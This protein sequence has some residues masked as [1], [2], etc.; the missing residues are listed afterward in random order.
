MKS[1]NRRI[2]EQVL[3]NI[4]LWI[5]ALTMIFPVL[6]VLTNSFIGPAEFLRYYGNIASHPTRYNPLHFIPDWI[7]LD[8]FKEVFLLRPHY[9]MKFWSSM[10]ISVTIVAG[11]MIIA[12]LGGYAFSRFRFPCRNI[13]FF[14]IILLMMLPLQVTLVPNYIMLDRFGLIGTYVAVILP[15]IFS[16]FGVF[17]MRQIM[18]SLPQSMFEAAK[19]DGAGAWRTLWRI[20]LPNCKTG[21]AALLVLCFADSWNMIEQPLVFLQYSNKYPMSVFL[22]QINTIS[23]EISFTCSVLSI[24]PTLLLFL[25]FK[26]EMVV[27]VE[28]TLVK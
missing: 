17:L 20:C 11:Q 10:L 7:T 25:A 14:L 4:V 28:S 19:L 5:V 24:L 22:T 21:I 12:V 1:N 13:I 18:V 27:G 3:K 9:L 2:F 15:G 16:A 26:D 6:Y 23:P 8:G